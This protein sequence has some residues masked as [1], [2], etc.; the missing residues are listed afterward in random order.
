MRS[1]LKRLF[2]TKPEDAVKF[3]EE[4]GCDTLAI[5]IGTA[6]GLYPKEFEPHLK[7][8]LLT[9]IKEKVSI[10]LVLHGGSAKPRFQ[11]NR[12]VKQ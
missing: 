9:E 1:V 7:Q 5:A 8:D 3:V 6:H 10:P 2:N 12:S 11:Q 4:T